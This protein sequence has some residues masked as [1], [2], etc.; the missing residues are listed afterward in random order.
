MAMEI[1]LHHPPPFPSP[2]FSVSVLFNLTPAAAAASSAHFLMQPRED[3]GGANPLPISLSLVECSGFHE[4]ASCFLLYPRPSP[5]PQ[6]FTYSSLSEG[7]RS[8]GAKL[9]LT[10]IKRCANLYF[11]RAAT[12]IGASSIFSVVCTGNDGFPQRN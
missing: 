11:S 7:S 2:P 10:S 3:G 1:A 8:R 4:P 6:P 9:L 5:Q 12:S